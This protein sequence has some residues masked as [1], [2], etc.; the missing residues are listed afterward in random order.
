LHGWRVECSL[1]DQLLDEARESHGNALVIRGEAGIG[2]SAL[3]DYAVAR[4]DGLRVLRGL[5]VE[6][7]LVCSPLV[8]P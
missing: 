5:R 7:C 3:L 4:A 1:I 8:P 6:F 2:K